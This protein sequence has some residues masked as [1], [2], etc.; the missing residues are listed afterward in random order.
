M[1]LP[2]FVGI[3]VTKCGTTWLHELLQQH[4]KIYMPQKRKE[5][6]FV[7][8]EENYH[9]GLSWY[10]SFF[11]DAKVSHDFQAIGE[12]SPR[13]LEQ[14]DKCASRLAA[15]TSVDK[16]IIML[17]NPVNRTYSQ[18]AHGLKAGYPKSFEDFL[19]E[20]PWVIEQ[21]Q[22]AEKLKPFL[23]F[24]DRQQICCFIFEESV[25][26]LQTT[27]QRLAS[28]LD[29]AVEEFPA[30]AGEERANQS[31]VPRFSWLNRW[32]GQA[33]RSL[34]S[35][36]LDWVINLAKS[37]KIQQLLRFGSKSKL[38]AMSASTRSHLQILFAE[39]IDNLE[40]VL[41]LDLTVWRQSNI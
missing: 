41:D 19:Q 15:I 21:S 31:Y 24:Y 3:G 16:L 6:N 37:L 36:D 9:K 28:F 35:Q 18:Y 33:N 39:D 8:L 11:P 25:S 5:I 23:E 38:P 29:V 14:S 22:Y 13:Y 20:R 32:A 34:T 26:N 30:V 40:K 1:T 10:E 7:N 4:P 17:R 27:K 12:F 2:N